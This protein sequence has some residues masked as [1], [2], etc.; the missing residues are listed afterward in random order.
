MF[1]IKGGRYDDLHNEPP[2]QFSD[3]TIP[4]AAAILIQE[5]GRPLHVSE[6]LEQ[7]LSGGMVFK[8]NHPEISIVVSLS[9]NQTF[10]KVGD[11]VFDLASRPVA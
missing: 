5:A 6:L 7:M 8:G 11:A 3:A 10:C 9:R 1:L 4:R 2:K